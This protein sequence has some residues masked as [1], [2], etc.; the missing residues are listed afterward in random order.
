MMVQR[1]FGLI[2]RKREKEDIFYLISIRTIKFFFLILIN[3]FF[4]ACSMPGQKT[5]SEKR[6]LELCSEERAL[7]TSPKTEINVSKGKKKTTFGASISFSSNFI[8][9][10]DPEKVYL[11]C[12]RRFK[13]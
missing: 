6:V 3:I 9:G 2:T 11:E 12:L 7:A 5:L 1:P 4:F 8:R 10:H 13:F